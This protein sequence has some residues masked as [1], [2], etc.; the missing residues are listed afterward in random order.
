MF[1]DVT[2][3]AIR[4]SAT[5]LASMIHRWATIHGI[6]FP[7]TNS[8]LYAR[9]AWKVAFKLKSAMY[10]LQNTH[11]KLLVQMKFLGGLWSLGKRLWL[12]TP[13]SASVV[14][15]KASVGGV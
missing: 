6:S 7:V 3:T 4:V 11:S 1:C 2:A 8:L 5:M 10:I 13:Q 9:T 15:G 14:L 12:A